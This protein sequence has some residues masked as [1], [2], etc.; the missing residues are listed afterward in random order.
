MAEV[1]AAVDCGNGLVEEPTGGDAG[2]R[3]PLNQMYEI[4]AEVPGID[5]QAIRTMCDFI[6]R[7]GQPCSSSS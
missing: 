5:M 1:Q 2:I 4:K 6:Q 7:A 3:A